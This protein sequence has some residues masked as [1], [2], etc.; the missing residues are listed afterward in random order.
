MATRS[1]GPAPQAA[2]RYWFRSS[3]RTAWP[4]RARPARHGR[5]MPRSAASASGRRRGSRRGRPARRCRPAARPAAPLLAVACPDDQPL[6]A[7]IEQRVGALHRGVE[8]GDARSAARHFRPRCGRVR[9]SATIAEMRAAPITPMNTASLDD[10]DRADAISAA[11]L[12]R[13]GASAEGRDATGRKVPRFP[14]SEQRRAK[15]REATQRQKR[16]PHRRV[17]CW[18]R[19]RRPVPAF[20]A[21][22]GLPPACLF[23]SAACLRNRPEPPPVRRPKRP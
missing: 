10:L 7:Q 3:D 19:C 18:N 2:R 14:P 6:V 20:P 21:C 12:R 22:R 23:L 1:C 16:A 15:R 13:A 17:G 4:S 9:G 8:I 5:A 11:V